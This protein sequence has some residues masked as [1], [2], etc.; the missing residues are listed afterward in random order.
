MCGSAELVYGWNMLADALGRPRMYLRSDGQALKADKFKQSE[1]IHATGLD[2]VADTHS[3]DDVKA[4]LEGK[5]F[6]AVVKQQ[7]GA[8]ICGSVLLRFTQSRLERLCH[9]SRRRT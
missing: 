3:Q 2:A 6:K 4:F 9:H 5:T 8:D 7:T 1:T